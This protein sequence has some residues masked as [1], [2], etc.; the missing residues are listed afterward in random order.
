MHLKDVYIKIRG[1]IGASCSHFIHIHPCIILAV[2]QL[3]DTNVASRG[4]H[5]LYAPC[6][7]KQEFGFTELFIMFHWCS[8]IRRKKQKVWG[9]CNERPRWAVSPPVAAQVCHQPMSPRPRHLNPAIPWPWLT[10]GLIFF[11]FSFLS[12]EKLI[13]HIKWSHGRNWTNLMHKAQGETVPLG[14]EAAQGLKRVL[15]FR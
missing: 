2:R 10:Y 4:Y 14:K 8:E 1:V 3:P 7:W 9:N 5:V 13:F 15:E 6:T 12:Q 11:F